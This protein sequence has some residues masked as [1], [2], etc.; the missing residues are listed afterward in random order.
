VGKSV[1][2][3]DATLAEADA[4]MIVTDH[5]AVDYAMVRRASRA[6]VDTRHVLARIPA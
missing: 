6:V 1:P 5:T 3:T 2:L 4:V